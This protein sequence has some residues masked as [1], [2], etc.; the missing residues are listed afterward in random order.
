MADRR[1][2]RGCALGLLVLLAGCASGPEPIDLED[3][4]EQQLLEEARNALAT[5]DLDRTIDTSEELLERTSDGKRKQEALFLAAEAYHQDDAPAKAFRHYQLLLHDFP[6]SPFVPKCEQP[7]YDIGIGYLAASPWPVF[8]DLFSGRER[9]AEVMREFAASF[10]SS[11]KTDDAL[12]ALA[13]YRFGRGE[14]PEAAASY[15]RLAKS[16]PD[17]EWADLAAFRRGE[18]WQLA[19]R[20]PAYDP[21]PLQKAAYNFRRYL[22]ERPHGERR[23]QALAAAKSVDE[24]IAE[25]ELLRAQLYVAREQERGARM[26]F[27]NIVLAYPETKAA[28]VARAELERHSWDLSIHC[29]DTLTLAPA[30]VQDQ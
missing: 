30:Q 27:A 13:G 7:V 24:L 29:V 2:R 1:S 20:G 22:S 23:D 3:L 15:S 8:H 4:A 28:A 14:F 12:A 21:T 18:C 11:S 19:A 25:A 9:G 17:S 10:P 26:H 6:W 5:G 16:Y